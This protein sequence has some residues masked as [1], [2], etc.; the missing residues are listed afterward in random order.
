[1]S[2][3]RTKD[4]QWDHGAQYFSP[5]SAAFQA[6]VAEWSDA[7]WCVPWAG[8]H[9]VWSVA[10]GLMTDPKA[11]TRYVGSPGMNS[12]CRGLLNG[13]NTQYSTRAVARRNNNKWAL[14]HGKSGQ[15]LGEFDFLICTDK[16]AAARHRTDL[17][18][19]V[20]DGFTKPATSLGS[21]Q[22]LALMM[23]TSA[24]ELDFDSLL[25]DGHPSIS[26]VAKDSE[27]PGRVSPEGTECWVLH[28]E[29]AFTQKLL[30][31]YR[32]DKKTRYA[33][34]MRTA[35]VRDLVPEFEKLVGELGGGSVEVL[36]AQG[37]RW[38]VAFPLQSFE[39]AFYFDAN[40][41]FGACGDYFTPHPGR[42]EGAWSSGSALAGAILAT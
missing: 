30:N 38:G 33:N 25:L 6:A 19:A 20:L 11:N 3:R 21:V 14:T 31:G 34:G 17:D 1:M 35:V 27:K 37:H 4:F 23:A 42:V 10:N 9:C 41:N 36:M 32:K 24:T 8:K 39:D 15:S 13:I 18:K 12:I 22:R 2:T 26:W 29:P 40:N 28:A 7:G 5:K 16:A